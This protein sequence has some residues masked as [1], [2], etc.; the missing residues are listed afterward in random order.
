VD[1]EQSMVMDPRN[2]P[3]P[4]QVRRNVGGATVLE[5]QQIPFPFFVDV[6]RDSMA[7]RSP[8]VANLPAITL[9]WASPV[10]VDEEKNKD[11]EVVTLLKSTDG[12]WLR[13]NVDTSPNLELYPEV[14]FPVEGEQKARVLAVSIR[15]SFESY[16]KDKPS[17]FEES[18]T[19]EGEEKAGAEA[20]T[21]TPEPEEEVALGTIEVSP[22]SSRL[23]VIGSA[24][25]LDDA[26]LE[27]SRNFSR[28]RYLNNLQFVQNAVDWSVEDEDLL[29]IRSRGTY[30]RLL[31]PL[32]KREQS[33][34]EALNYAVA[35]LAL[36]GIGVVWSIRQR[37]EQPLPLPGIEHVQV[38]AE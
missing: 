17:P 37:S 38:E 26:I 32:D 16:F 4:V 7:R 15:G 30:A 21:P 6:R 2:E 22:E 11:R 5:F 20:A 14:G 13:T 8:I 33:L 34:W 24:E 1:V 27:M 35:L 25:F 28:D 3:F 36:A 10:V 29:S 31:K 23:V 12:A 18:E 9:H 19:Q